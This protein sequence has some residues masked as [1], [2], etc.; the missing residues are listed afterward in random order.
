MEKNHLGTPKKEKLGTGDK[1][2]TT[3]DRR[4]VKTTRDRWQVK[5]TRDRW[6]VKTTRD[7][8]QV[9]TTRDRRQLS[10]FLPLLP[11]LLTDQNLSDILQELRNDPELNTIDERG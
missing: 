6:Q 2:K 7:R 5:T 3:R 9:K 10:K 1:S 8:W 4:Q 11:A